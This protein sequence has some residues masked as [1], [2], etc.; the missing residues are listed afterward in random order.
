MNTIFSWVTFSVV[1]SL[2]V[3]GCMTATRFQI[4]NGTEVNVEVKSY[5][6]QKK[7]SIAV[8]K[9]EYLYHTFG[10]ISVFSGETVLLYKNMSPL[11]FRNTKWIDNNRS[12]LNPTLTVCLY[13]NTNGSFYV[14]AKRRSFHN[15][16]EAQPEGYPVEPVE[17]V[18]KRQVSR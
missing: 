2:L 1:L 10:D 16:Q 15:T 3:S 6:T 8:G 4:E 11:Q 17:F 13:L 9:Q 12:L 18:A 5:H 7:I 14:V